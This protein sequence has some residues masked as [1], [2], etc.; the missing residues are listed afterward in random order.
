MNIIIFFNGWG[1]DEKILE[2]LENKINYEILNVSF[3][4]KIDKIK[5]NKY[6]KKY[7]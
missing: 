6:K 2:K 1:M 7:L 4:Y 3:P 5:L